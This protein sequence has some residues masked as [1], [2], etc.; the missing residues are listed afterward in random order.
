VLSLACMLR[1]ID[2]LTKLTWK[3]FA[4]MEKSNNRSLNEIYLFRLLY[5]LKFDW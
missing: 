4:Q 1:Y 5:V 2:C 3:S